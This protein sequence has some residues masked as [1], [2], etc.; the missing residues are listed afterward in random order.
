MRRISGA[1]VMLLA[2]LSGCGSEVTP[3][4][5]PARVPG[6]D[7][8]QMRSDL[9]PAK[10]L[11]ES[12]DAQV[13]PPPFEDAPLVQ[14]SA[15]ETARFVDAYNRVGHPRILVWVMHE[16]TPGFDDTA[17]RSIDWSAMQTIL[18]DWLSAG[19][20]V[21]LISPEAARQSLSPQE[22]QT[23]DAGQAVIGRDVADRIHADILVLVRAESTR[24]S[25]GEPALRLVAEA[26]NLSGGES[27]G[28]A[29]ADVPPP[30]DKPRLN[31]FT[32]FLAR[33]LM[34]EMTQSWTVFGDPSATNAR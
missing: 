27:I 14:Q 22:A 7:E 33:K 34:Q 13:P 18:G 5:A 15:P 26:M 1:A 17:I 12:A 6:P 32:R 20:H 10:P 30:L 2:F 31:S 21:A 11:P 4:P 9:P 16:M 29:V 3:P 24:Q 28:R 23:L 8:R 19:G 25:G